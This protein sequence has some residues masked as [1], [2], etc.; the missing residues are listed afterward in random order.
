MLQKSSIKKGHIEVM[1][2]L[3]YIDSTDMIRLGEEHAIPQPQ[4]YEMVAF[5]IV[6]TEAG[7]CLHQHH[8]GLPPHPN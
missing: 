3:D 5:R 1:K 2:R 8:E 7:H 4:W 6:E